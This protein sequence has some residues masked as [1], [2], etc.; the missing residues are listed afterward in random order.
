MMKSLYSGVSGMKTHTQRM[1]VIGNNIANVNTTGYKTSTVTFKDIYYQTKSNASSGSATTGGK[2]PTQVGYGASVGTINQMMT[3]S[4]FTYSDSVYDCAIQGEGFFQVMDDAGNIYYSRAGVFSVDNYGN[5]SDPNGYIVLGVMGDP[6]NAP[7]SSQRISLVVPSVDNNVASCTKLINGY[8]VTISA[9]G[10][11]PE[12]N[13]SLTILDGTSPFATMSGSNLQVT[14]DLSQ[15][16]E[17]TDQ[18]EAA[19]NEAIRAGGIDLSDDVLPI[20][21]EM[22]D[23]PTNIDPINASNYITFSDPEADTTFNL[24]FTAARAGEFANAY[25][26]NIKSSSSITA[27]SAKWTN[28]VLTITVPSG[29]DED[30]NPITFNLEDLQNA[31]N[32]AAGMVQDDAGEW[33][34]GNAN[35]MLNVMAYDADGNEDEGAVEGFNYASVLDGKTLR[36]GLTGGQDSFFADIANSLSTVKLEDGRFSAAQDVSDLSEVYIDS[37]GTVYGVHPVHG[38]F[39]MAR[40]DIVTFENPIGLN[41]VGTSYWQESLASGEPNVKIAGQDGAGEVVSGALE[42]SNVDLSQEMSDM[43]ITQRGF[44]ANSRIIT[45]SDTMLEEL[46]NLKR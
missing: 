29:V 17:S 2:N 12:G 26:I 30:E 19:V 34:G 36:T 20:H 31:I 43:I 37:D 1:D 24:G 15:T 11:G 9:N 6:Q 23:I 3:Q 14:M 5:L 44:Q 8:E 40:I 22:D 28:D 27:P 46:V 21:I 25:E 42:M 18:F 38:I 4:G 41:Q 13:I 10:Y 35:K 7:A 45:V 39:A 32:K 16:F 33:T